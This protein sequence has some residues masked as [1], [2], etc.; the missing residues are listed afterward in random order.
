MPNAQNQQGRTASRQPLHFWRHPAHFQGYR[1]GEDEEDARLAPLLSNQLSVSRNNHRR[2]RIPWSP[3]QTLGSELEAF[4]S[5]SMDYHYYHASDSMDEGENSIVNSP[6]W[7]CCGWICCC[8]RCCLLSEQEV[9]SDQQQ[10][11]QHPAPAHPI[12]TNGGGYC[13]NLLHILIFAATF[14]GL[15]YYSS[16]F[17]NQHWTMNPGE[18]RHVATAGILTDTVQ[19]VSLTPSSGHDSQ[20]GGNQTATLGM[21]VYATGSDMDCPLLT[22]DPVTVDAPPQEIVLLHNAFQYQYFYMNMGSTMQVTVYQSRGA[23][24]ILVLKGNKVLAR[25]QNK[26]KKYPP[27]P[28]ESLSDFELLFSTEEVVLERVAWTEQ[29]API[30]FS[31]TSPANDVYVLLFDNSATNNPAAFNVSYH[32]V[33][34]AYNLKG[35]VPWCSHSGPVGTPMPSLSEETYFTC[36]PLQVASAGCII[37]EATEA[38]GHRQNATTKV[39][40]YGGD[41]IEI[42]LYTTRRWF[43]LT[44]LSILPSA[45]LASASWYRQRKRRAPRR[46][47]LHYESTPRGR[48]RNQDLGPRPSFQFLSPHSSHGVGRELP[49]GNESDERIDADA[50]TGNRNR[51]HS[52]TSRTVAQDNGEE[53]MT[54]ASTVIPA[55]SVTVLKEQQP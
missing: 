27:Y 4:N 10:Q 46:E 26:R 15:C 33:L 24:N 52:S 8:C 7:S 55:E 13:L 23:C 48:H 30:E 19:V 34:T 21:A 31:F 51:N 50:L 9:H 54:D 16:R 44:L 3:G 29:G 22:G 32:M 45:F 37:V 25:I 28:E 5:P 12:N 1:N 14:V 40:F 35:L 18:N 6:R 53:N 49:E 41:N 36:P 43:F 39:S 11:F 2:S 42:T 38:N 47:R 17:N 20:R